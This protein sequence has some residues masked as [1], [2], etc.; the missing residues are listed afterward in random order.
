MT[1]ACRFTLTAGAM[2]AVTT[3]VPRLLLVWAISVASLANGLAVATERTRAEGTDSPIVLVED[4]Q[5]R[6]LIVT[7]ANPSRAETFAAEELQVYVK[8]ISGAE[9]DV[10]ATDSPGDAPAIIVGR[11]PLAAHVVG[12]MHEHCPNKYDA[13]AVVAENNR[14]YLVGHSET[15]TVWAA[16]DWLESL[17][18][19]WLMPTELGEYVPARKDIRV[20]PSA[21]YDAP[22]LDFRGPN[23]SMSTA[24]GAPEAAVQKERGMSASFLFSCRMRLNNNVGFETADTWPSIGSGHSYGKFLPPSRY[25]E[26]HPEWFNLVDGRRRKDRPWQVCFTNREAAKEFAKNLCATVARTNEKSGVPVEHMRLFV[27]PNDYKARCECDRCQKL[28]DE[29]GSATSLVTHFANMVA[30]EVRRKY[31]TARIVFYAYD[32]YS[33]PPDHV[34]PG[35]GVQPEVVFWTWNG[36]F[37][38]N[39]A[40]P[41]FSD[42]NDKYR[43]C[44]R[45]WAEISDGLSSHEYYGHYTWFTPWPKVTQM[46]TD[47]RTMA[48]AKSFYGMYSES[49]L[50]WGTQGLTFYLHPKLMWNPQLDVEQAIAV[51]C[52]KAFGPAGPALRE[53][54][55]V[56]QARMDALDYVCGYAVEI[57]QLLTPDVVAK[58]NALMDTAEG[59]L[60]AMDPD[61][62][63]RTTVYLQAWRASAK[64]AEAAR[65]Y[66]HSAGPEAR[67]RILALTDEVRSFAA[68]ELGRWAFERRVAE[69]AIDSI[70]RNLQLDWNDLPEGSHVFSDSFKHGGAIKF[71]AQFSGWQRGMWG[72]S[73]PAR[74]RGQVELPLRASDGHRITSAKLRWNFAARDLDAR[75]A[76]V[77]RDSHEYVLAE[78]LEAAGADVAVPEAAL[79]GRELVFRLSVTSRH[80]DPQNVLTGIHLEVT[81]D[82]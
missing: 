25:H 32:N 28:V 80:A 18:V 12:K 33:T 48:A 22:A 31:P 39:H 6:G 46:S 60:G 45:E 70:S 35:R 76:V 20:P 72:Y 29:D 24:N 43:R 16:W 77:G 62:R 44:F 34:T 9:L 8:K 61:T 78:Q 54:F 65:L 38:A 15:G 40:H 57:P 67:K 82:R 81:V 5:P 19:R 26:E 71:F 55:R 58:C 10:V 3:C 21:K 59:H 53:Y 41:M 52:D 47:L 30:E 1:V 7:P 37:G 11:H 42:A 17:G 68:T 23:Y 36:S 13:I 69:R 79:G 14:L 49:H 66:V 73:L 74:G 51:Y 50:H 2:W 75:L 64:F 63:W 4:G 56:L 27:S